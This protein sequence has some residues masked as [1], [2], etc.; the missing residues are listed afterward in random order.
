MLVTLKSKAAIVEIDTFGAEV[1]SF[2][3]VLGIEYLWQGDGAYWHGRA[4]MLFPM[5]GGLRNGKAIVDGKEVS[6]KR[7]GFARISEFSLVMNTDTMAVFSLK[8]NEEI[9]RV[10]PYDFELRITYRLEDATLSK[11][12][13]VVNRG[14][15][16]MPFTWGGH[17]AYN[18]PLLR[19]EKFEDYVVEFEKEEVANCPT[20]QE[21]TGLIMLD[22]RLPL[23]NGE[24][25]FS[26]RH[27]LFYHDCLIFDELKS[28][29][30]RLYCRLSGKG[31]E[32]NFEGFPYLGIWSAANDAPFVCLEPWT[33][34]AT[35]TNEDDIFEHKRGMKRLK[36]GESFTSQYSVSIL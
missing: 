14:Q 11:E 29:K 24:K 6:M 35:C 26:L 19:D 28:R 18:V 22:K 33:G 34:F 21:E 8:P 4:P 17:T 23:L 1:Q 20:L 9:R 10:Y 30:V 16:E 5:V 3:D 13:Y 2:Q 15:K 25:M 32:L 7:H 12:L 31:V 36:E 27:D